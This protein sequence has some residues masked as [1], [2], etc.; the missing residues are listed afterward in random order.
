M[1][2]THTTVKLD[3]KSVSLIRTGAYPSHMQFTED[4]RQVGL[5][6]TG[7]GAMTIS[8]YASRVHNTIGENGGELALDY[9]IE[10]DN[11][12][13]GEHHFEMVVTP[14]P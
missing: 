3:G 9:T 5:Y 8:V 14:Q 11:S 4:E 7:A 10:V 12:L 2:G 13:A 6:A 1:E